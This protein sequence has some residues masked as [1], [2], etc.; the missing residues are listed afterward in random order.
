MKFRSRGITQK[1]RFAKYRK[2]RQCVLHPSA[3]MNP[4]DQGTVLDFSAVC[5][6]TGDE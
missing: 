3:K 1:K 6:G 5:T 4:A 2:R